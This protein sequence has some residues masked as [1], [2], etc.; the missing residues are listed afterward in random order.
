[1]KDPSMEPKLGV[2]SI[3]NRPQT[4]HR[5]NASRKKKARPSGR[6]VFHRSRRYSQRLLFLR[7]QLEVDD[8]FLPGIEGAQRLGAARRSLKIRLQLV[9]HIGTQLIKMVCP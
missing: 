5:F 8:G 1:M 2:Y 3:Q 7:I 9:I 6:T 4:S